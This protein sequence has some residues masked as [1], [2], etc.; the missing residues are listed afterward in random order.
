MVYLLAKMGTENSFKLYKIGLT[1][2]G[3]ATPFYQDFF[4]LMEFTQSQICDVRFYSHILELIIQFL[5]E[6]DSFSS[7]NSDMHFVYDVEYPVKSSMT[8]DFYLFRK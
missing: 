6:L 2:I 5:N 8:K 3:L 1:T 4:F 7:A